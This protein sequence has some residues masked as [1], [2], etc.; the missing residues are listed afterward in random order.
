MAFSKQN[1][2][3]KQICPNIWAQRQNKIILALYPYSVLARNSQLEPSGQNGDIEVAKHYKN[4][5]IF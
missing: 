3:I 2:N 5:F 1:G 4:S